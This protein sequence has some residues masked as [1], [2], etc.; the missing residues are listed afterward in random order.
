M[1]APPAPAQPC[2]T[3][4]AN[5]GTYTV[6]L[7]VTDNR[8]GTN[9]VTHPV[10]VVDPPPNILPVASFTTGT[11]YRTVNFASTSTDEDGTIATHAW[12]FGDGT[13]GNGASVSHTYAGPGTYNVTLSVTDNRG[14][15]ATVTEWRD[16]HGP[17]RGRHVRAHRCERARYRGQRRRL[18]ALRRGRELLRQQRRRQDH[19]RR[20]GN[21]SAYLTSVQQTDVDVKATVALDQ[22]STGGGAYVSLIGRRVSNGNDYRLKL[23]Y[24]A[25]GSVAAYLVRTVGGV[26][27]VVSSATLPG[28]TVSP[29]DQLKTR[30]VVTGTPNTTIRGKVWR[31]GTQ[32]PVAW[33]LTNT[34]ATPAV[35]Q[36]PGHVGTLVYV[37]GSWTGAAPI[38]SID[39]LT[40]GPDSGPPVN[41]PPTASF[42]ASARVPD[43]LVRRDDVDRP[44]RRHDH[45]YAWNFGDGTTGTGSTP[46]HEYAA[47]GTYNATLTVTDNGGLTGTKTVAVEVTAPPPPT[48]F[49]IANLAF[50]TASFDGNGSSDVDGTITDYAWDFGDGNTGTGPTPDHVYATAGIYTVTLTVTDDDGNH[51]T[52]SEEFEFGDAPPPTAAFTS[53][54]NFLIASFDGTTSSDADGT[55]TD[56][57]WDFGDGTTGSGATPTHLYATGGT[58]NVT[59]TVTDNG[60]NTGTTSAP[61]VITNPPAQYA[62]DVFGR[63]VTNGLGTADVGG[64]WTLSGA[65]TSFSVNNGV[66]R[67]AGAVAGNRAGYLQSVAQTDVNMT[68]DVALDSASTGGGAYVSI[69]GR[70]VS[71]NN[72]YRLMLRYMP[73]GTV[74][75]SLTKTIGGTQT[76]LSTTTVPGLTV[77]PG[78]VLRTRFVITGTTNTALQAKVWRASAAEP[79]TWTTTATEATPSVLQS[80][81]GVGVL[82]YVSGSWVG[83]APAVTVDN[84]NVI[85]PTP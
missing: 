70:R 59:L 75:A 65:A 67:I 48:A 30:L 14:G 83:T 1:T 52:I 11:T 57:A 24:Q 49:F 17:V 80:P 3:L 85:A 60:G 43:G 41:V 23:R 7:T 53:S 56:Y 69:V 10:T 28:L 51:G 76:V 36:A 47:A 4:Y 8:G 45:D 82:L 29:G 15:P 35:L 66:G 18:D 78:D 34:S 50:L 73:N 40:A 72:D 16:H 61:I 46:H 21:R 13:T 71:N 38:A 62:A 26:E 31:K 55:I 27:T 44:R 77:A 81:G 25:G 64:A 2:R 5:A 39:N 32:E 42:T 33:S 84:L 79:A 63:T 68:T 20:N 9:T 19:G 22:A 58:Y 54:S 74:Q 12:N 37:S 6:A